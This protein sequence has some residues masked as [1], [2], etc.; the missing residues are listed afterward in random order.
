MT[1]WVLPAI[2]VFVVV[3]LLLVAWV[4]YRRRHPRLDQAL[5]RD[6]WQRLQSADPRHAILEADKLLDYALT[7]RGHTGTLGDKLKAAGKCFSDLNGIWA[8]HKLRN[9]LAHELDFYPSK[10][11]ITTALASF[12]RALNDLGAQ[13]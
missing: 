5:I 8:A 3:D 6:S 10:S 9:R 4:F 2:A 1:D 11:E 13:L 7:S 12:N